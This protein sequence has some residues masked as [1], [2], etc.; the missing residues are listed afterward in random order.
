[1]YKN[2][3]VPIDLSHGEQGERILDIARR[4]GGPD[5]RLVALHVFGEI[6]G[7]VIAEMPKDAIRKNQERSEAELKA[8][9]DKA[10]A[11]AIVRT[12]HPS[13]AILEAAEKLGADLIVIA[14][15]RPGFEDYFLGSTAARVA[16]HSPCA[17]LIDR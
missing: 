1:M 14:S 2:I 12:G 8:L 17:V 4:I 9:A 6:P 3:L 5:A 13:T 16:R 7:Y 15:H 10:G 11:E